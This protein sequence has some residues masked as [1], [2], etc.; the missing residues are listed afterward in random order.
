MIAHLKVDEN[1]AITKKLSD[2]KV[3][4][5]T[6]INIMKFLQ[7]GQKDYFVK[8]ANSAKDMTALKTVI[9]EAQAQDK[10]ESQK[11]T[12]TVKFVGLDAKIV[13]TV[14]HR[15]KEGNYYVTYEHLGL[16]KD[17]IKYVLGA[18]VVGGV[19]GGLTVTIEAQKDTEDMIVI[20]VK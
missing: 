2:A 6:T 15:I 8:R 14:T 5:K 4:A 19:S 9:D 17:N 13:K 1:N 12:V 11:G 7:A 20:D 3:R 18:K 10:I 16:T